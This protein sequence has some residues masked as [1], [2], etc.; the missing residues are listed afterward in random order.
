MRINM[1]KTSAIFAVLLLVAGA[2][3]CAAEPAAPAADDQAILGAGSHW[4]YHVVLSAPMV[5]AASAKAAGVANDEPSRR[6]ER[7][8]DDR[9]NKTPPL[10]VRNDPPPVEWTTPGFDDRDWAGHRGPLQAD[11]FGTSWPRELSPE[12]ALVCGRFKFVVNN[13]A[14]VKKLLLSMKFRGGLVVY[15]N[16]KEVARSS[17]PAGVLQPLTPGDD[18]PDD[19]TLLNKTTQLHWYDNR[20]KAEQFRKRDRLLDWTPLDATLLRQGTNV[21]A[22]EIHRSDYPVEC[23]KLGALWGANG[24]TELH[25]KAQASAGAIVGGVA[26]PAGVQVW[27]IDIADQM[28]DL[29]Y[30]DPAEPLAPIRIVAARNGVFSGAVAVGSTEPIEALAARVGDLKNPAG[31]AIPAAAVSVRYGALDGRSVGD[32]A[33]GIPARAFDG[34]LE[35]PPAI[36]APTPM[37][38]GKSRRAELGLP[39]SPVSGAVVR[40]WVAVKVPREAAPGQYR[41]QLAISAKGWPPTTVPIELTLASHTL[42]D[43]SDY[44]SLLNVY[45][46]PDTL[47]L[48]YKV[49]PWSQEHWALIDRSLALMG[50]LGNDFL[51][52]PLL[53]KDQFGNDESMVYWVKE[54]GPSPATAPASGAYKH[55][56]TI[57]DHYLDLFLKHHDARR[58]KAAVLVP[59]GMAAAKDQATVTALDPATGKKTDVLLPPYGTSECEELWRPLLLAVRDRLKARGLGQQ[60]ML[61]MPADPNPLPRHVAMFHNILPEAPWMRACHPDGAS[62]SYDASDRQKTVPIVC[63]EHVWWSPI[64]DPAVKRQFGWQFPRMRVSFN[65]A[66][67]SPLVLNGF[68]P[69]WDFR[70][71][72]EASL[73]AGD[74][75]AGRVGADF[76]NQGIKL[77]T[78]GVRGGSEWDSGSVGTLYNR[79]PTSQVGQTGLGAGI[80]DLLAAGPTGPVASIRYENAREGIQSAEAVIALE[81][82][83]VEKRVPGELED[84]AWQLIDR[85]I[86][87]LRLHAIDLGQAGWQER[88]RQL[89]ELAPTLAPSKP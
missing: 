40:V 82:A 36:I 84:R 24:L 48:H 32:R 64:S 20:D 58:I 29:D 7:I 76:F 39:A 8:A 19:V 22:V 88:S 85:R 5:S 87:C 44:A 83:L 51:C 45:Q 3:T 10:G 81:K 14:A 65:R 23:K 72:I 71:W 56:F 75:G 28:L 15:L 69:P 46:S 37:A 47:A 73:A 35:Q 79:F 66:G 17:L 33:H 54:G 55:D 78:Q 1:R 61:G 67:Y 38:A 6:I 62:L 74:R 30:A 27:N 16:G 50:E 77:P 68:R 21:L 11:P 4:R 53:S 86:N 31:A 41:G 43:V 25:L 52:I 57:L 49:A 59:W 60:L 34:L 2:A 18:Y 13:P 26:R 12:F 70:M 9:A 63:N 89:F 80:T 42:P